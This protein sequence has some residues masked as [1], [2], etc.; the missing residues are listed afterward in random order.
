MGGQFHRFFHHDVPD[1][2][3]PEWT[4]G[5]SLLDGYPD[6]PFLCRL[7]DR[8]PSGESSPIYSGNNQRRKLSGVEIAGEKGRTCQKTGC[9]AAVVV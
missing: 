3:M 8:T 6:E 2:L 7:E 9:I 1:Q 4:F 5:R